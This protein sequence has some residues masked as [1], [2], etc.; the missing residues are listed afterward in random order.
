M[1]EAPFDREAFLKTLPLR[2]GVYRMLGEDDAVLYVG[3]ARNLKHRV[4]SYFRGR[5]HED[6]TQAMLSQIRRIEITVTVSETEALLL[7]Y[8]LIKRHRPRYNVVL[9]DDKSFPYIH[10]TTHRFPRLSFYRGPRG[11]ATRFRRSSASSR[12]SP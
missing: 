6:R 8:N 4:T 3:K 12:A 5:T 2:P 9:K 11:H 10:L 1:A 7:E